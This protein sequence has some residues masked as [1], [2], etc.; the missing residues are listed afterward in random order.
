MELVEAFENEIDFVATYY[1]QI[2][3]FL[4]QPVPT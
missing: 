4:K 1:P 2:R 3:T